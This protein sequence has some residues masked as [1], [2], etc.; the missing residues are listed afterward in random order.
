M[1]DVE[2]CSVW[3]VVP[4]EDGAGGGTVGCFRDFLEFEVAGFLQCGQGRSDGCGFT[5][6]NSG[7][8]W[9]IISISG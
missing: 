5:E 6:G 4:E 1:E 7:E 8:L 3:V 9:D 2:A